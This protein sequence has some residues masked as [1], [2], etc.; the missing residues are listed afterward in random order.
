MTQKEMV[1]H[2]ISELPDDASFADIADRVQFLAALQKGLDEIDRGETIPHE[3]VKR[4]IASW[5]TS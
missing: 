5:L 2:S 3:E 1:L 4:Q